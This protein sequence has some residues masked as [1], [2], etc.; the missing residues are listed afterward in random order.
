MEFKEPK[1]VKEV[2]NS[3]DVSQAKSHSEKTKD[4]K[5]H[6]KTNQTTSTTI[7]ALPESGVH[8]NLPAMG[9]EVALLVFLLVMLVKP[10]LKGVNSHG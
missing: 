5:Q 4:V 10:L 7:S 3:T 9:F 8:N 6:N 2:K 1:T